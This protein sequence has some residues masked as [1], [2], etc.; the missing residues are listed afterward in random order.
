MKKTIVGV[1]LAK[2]V[3]QVCVYANMKVRSNAE[4]TPNEFALW[5]A[6]SKP[7]T[8]IFEACRT[9]NYWKQRTASL[10]HDARLISPNFVASARQNQKTDKNDALAIIQASLLPDVAFVSGKSVEQ[11]QL[12]S[13]M[14]MRELCMKQ[15]TAAKNQIIALLSEFNI[16][17]SKRKGGLLRVIESTL[18]DAENGFSMEFRVAFCAA[19]EQYLTLVETISTYDTCLEQSIKSHPDCKKLLKIEGIGI[20]NAINLYIALG[21]ADIVSFTKGKDA[22]ACIGLTP[23]QHSSGGKSKVGSIGR[24]TKNTILSSQLITGA[25]SIVNHLGTRAAKTK[26][27]L[28]LKALIERRGKKCAAVAL[29]NKNVRTAFALLT[30]GSK[31]KADPVS[32]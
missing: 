30:Q 1:D 6:N 5:L 28:W 24:R 8:V 2:K 15:K 7:M 17:V 16:I 22:A 14:R 12:L 26:K 31:Y 11:Q 13:I 20:L 4:M 18:E 25:M 27:E 3:V 10:G 23:I 21:C 9:S 19:K 29:A 32:A